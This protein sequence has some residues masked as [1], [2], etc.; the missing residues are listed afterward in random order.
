MDPTAARFITAAR[1]HVSPS[2]TS[3]LA[4]TALQATEA[5][6]LPAGKA[7]LIVI[8]VPAQTA[9]DAIDRIKRLVPPEPDE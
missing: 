6:G 7:D 5:A 3:L 8:A 2:P 4:A 1:L 9:G